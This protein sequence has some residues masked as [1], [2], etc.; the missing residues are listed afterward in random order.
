[1]RVPRCEEAW[2][3]LGAEGGQHG[4][5][6]LA[7]WESGKGECEAVRSQSLGGLRSWKRILFYLKYSYKPLKALEQKN[8]WLIHWDPI[9]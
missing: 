6:I 5:Q 9:Y 7:E 2:S 4:Q 1:V 3:V 8:T